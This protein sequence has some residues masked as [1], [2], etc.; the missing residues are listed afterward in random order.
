MK[1]TAN[2]IK[3]K[4]GVISSLEAGSTTTDGVSVSTSPIEK[5]GFS[6]AKLSIGYTTTLTSAKTLKL[7]S[8]TIS[9]STDNSIWST[10]VAI[11]SDVLLG[12]GIS[13]GGTVSDVFELALK[14]FRQYDKYVKFA[15]IPE[16]DASAS[17]T[18][19]YNVNLILCDSDS[20]PV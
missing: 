5:T 18:A 12:T 20:V 7:T 1:D 3:S 9:D 2:Q 8:V 16:L 15:F 19:T 14:D 6:S 4:F 17:D 11:A 13:G 10:P